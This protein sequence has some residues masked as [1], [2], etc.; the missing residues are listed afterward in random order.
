MQL[1]SCEVVDDD[2]V[3]VSA[4]AEQQREPIIS[5][6]CPSDSSRP[7]HKGYLDFVS[8]YIDSISSIL[9]PISLKIHDNPELN[10]KEYIA[11]ATLTAFLSTRKGWTVTPSAY[12]LE[13]AF[14][15]EYDS[16]KKGP[17]VSFNAEYDALTGIG[18]SCGHNL[19]AICSVGA[20]LAAGAAMTELS[21]PGK[22]ILFGTPAEEG[23]GGKIKL[24]DAGA[25]SDHK[26]DINLISHPGNV[27]AAALVRTNAYVNFRVEYFGKEAH[28]AAS[29]W[30]GINAL[31]GLITGY[32]ALS[33]LR[34]QTMPGDIIQGHITDGGIAP[35]IIHAYAAGIFVVRALTK[36]RLAVLRAKVVKCFEAGA[37]ASGARLVITPLMGYDD[38]VPNK[39]LGGV[40]RTA[41]NQLGGA[42]P[43]AELDLIY[44]ATK[45]STDQGNISYAMP[46]LSLSFQI[47]SEVGPHNPGFAKAARTRQAHN[48]ALKAGKA[49]AVTG[50]EILASEDLLKA[51]KEEFKNISDE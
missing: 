14:I 7:L 49:L 15:A 32:N 16:G 23:G 30:E 37:E 29:P 3:N 51:A 22:V 26:V 20:A 42:I 33:V 5:P 41:F 31:D 17:V 44:G 1:V 43:T 21:L 47:D 34:Q 36:K 50:L 8:D 13:T 10:F 12:G 27:H 19:I 18:H 25:Y 35:N 40:C 46:S 48:A 39:V 11:H 9:R 38:H 2:Y 6:T 45:A 28:A 24:L 4:E